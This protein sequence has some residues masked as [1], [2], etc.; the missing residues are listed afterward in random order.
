[1][2][3]YESKRGKGGPTDIEENNGETILAKKKPCFIFLPLSNRKK[4]YFCQWDSQRVAEKVARRPK[5]ALINYKEKKN[6]N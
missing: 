5:Y 1:M 6:R 4:S 3:L 2:F